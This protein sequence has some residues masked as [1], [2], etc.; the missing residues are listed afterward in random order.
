[1]QGT[2]IDERLSTGM[3]PVDRQLSGGIKPGSLLAINAG[4][5]TQSESLLHKII[6]TRPTLYLT[7][8]RKVEAVESGLPKPLR[9]NVFVKSVAQQQS[10][11]NEFL[12]EVTGSGSYNPTFGSSDSIVDA[13]YEIISNIDRD[14]NVIV[15]PT[16]PLEESENKDVYREVLNELKATMLETN[17]LGVL[18]CIRAE[19]SPALRDTTLTI[20]DVVWELE[21]S[22]KM[23]NQEYELT[24]PKNRT[25]TPVLD[26]ITIKFDADVWVDE[27]RTI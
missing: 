27:T 24:I 1:M 8:L 2:Q 18:H 20:S 9:D 3:Q 22:T 25:G 14:I 23:D 13:V 7:T 17:G 5:S 11:D 15:D 16:N 26:K 19:E 4:P 10:M 6:G 12:R 21:L